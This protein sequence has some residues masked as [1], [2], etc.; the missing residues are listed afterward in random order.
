MDQR[1]SLI[2]LG[3]DDPQLV[4]RESRIVGGEVM[5]VQHAALGATAPHHVAGR[6]R[7]GRVG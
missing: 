7:P 2:T 3:V 5:E 6:R 4:L 1:V